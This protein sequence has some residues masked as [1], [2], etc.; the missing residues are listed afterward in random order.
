MG[1]YGPDT[2]LNSV[3]QVTIQEE[4]WLQKKKNL[5]DTG[6][7]H[8]FKYH[9]LSQLFEIHTYIVTLWR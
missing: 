3:K 8:L 6:V 2:W 5:Y 9:V 1:I 7:W 4:Q